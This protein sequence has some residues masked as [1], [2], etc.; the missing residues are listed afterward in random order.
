[1]FYCPI[2][3]AIASLLCRLA[4]GIVTKIK[5]KVTTLDEE[6]TAK[7]SAALKATDL[8]LECRGGWLGTLARLP[9]LFFV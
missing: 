5:G 2:L 3:Q 8:Q 7:E 1:L 9:Y 4:E 6:V